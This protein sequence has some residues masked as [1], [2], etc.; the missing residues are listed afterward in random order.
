MNGTEYVALIDTTR[1]EFRD[2]IADAL[3][4]F[5]QLARMADPAARP[6]GH[7]WTVQQIV[8]HVLTIAD[9]YR[10]GAQG[11]AYRTVDSTGAIAT[12]NQEELEAV[13]KPVP[14][15]LDELQSVAGELE[16]ALDAFTDETVL[17][18]H[19]F[20]EVSGAAWQSYWLGELLMHGEDIA[21]AVTVPRW[22]IRERDML[23]MLRGMMEIGHVYV[24]EDI[25]RDI[26]ISVALRLS[27]A[28]PY[29]MH[30]HDGIAEVRDLRP[31][32]RPDAMLRGPAS[33]IAQMFYGRIGLLAAAHRGLLI[34]GGRRPWRAIKLHVLLRE[35]LIH[36]K[37][38]APGS[39]SRCAAGTAAS[40]VDRRTTRPARL[41]RSTSLSPR[42]FR[43]SS[44]R[45]ATAAGLRSPV[46]RRTA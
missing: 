11:H 17:P 10:A 28:R 6:P 45:A 31:A 43:S 4:R 21:L 36:F 16:I 29:L 9:R 22:E 14:A 42:I 1:D 38:G 23:L 2:R 30:I 46:K 26:N 24:R 41:R 3:A 35:A 40:T 18:F 15:L 32:D 44:V 19:T 7:D 5:D 13:L 34:V 37:F 12:L 25:S 39:R 27:G 33:V 20:A 8:A